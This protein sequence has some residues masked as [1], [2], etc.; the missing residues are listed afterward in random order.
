MESNI[1]ALSDFQKFKTEERSSRFRFTKRRKSPPP[2]PSATTANEEVYPKNKRKYTAR[3]SVEYVIINVGIIRESE[4]EGTIHIVRGSKLPISVPRTANANIVRQLAKE[5]HSNH[6]QFFC[7]LED[8]TLLY[9]DQKK[10]TFIPGTTIPFNV[11][12][13]KNELGKPFSK[14]DL[15]LCQTH[16][17]E[18]GELNRLKSELA[19]PLFV[20]SDDDYGCEEFDADKF[21]N[22]AFD[23]I[24]DDDPTL[25]LTDKD[26]PAIVAVVTSHN[27]KA[28]N[29]NLTAI[30]GLD[31]QPGPSSSGNNGRNCGGFCPVCN[32][33]IP[34]SIIERHVDDC[35]NKREQPI[36]Y[37]LVES[38]EENEMDHYS[39]EDKCDTKIAEKKII[40]FQKDIPLLLKDCNVIKEEVTISIRRQNA[41]EDFKRFF[42][43]K[44]NQKNFNKTYKISLIGE[45][46]IDIGGVSREFYS[47]LFPPI[48][49][50]I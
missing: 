1:L 39:D 22:S 19:K 49:I 14:I 45:P 28:T 40:N 38:D 32:K 33:R 46:A 48:Y 26:E 10:V 7:G 5:K 21:L 34:F 31:Q 36:I 24:P 13:Y 27:L 15:Y 42:E 35:L 43:K 47:G 12:R 4:K 37:N 18:R 11:E 2:P 6:D 41:F 30:S 17:L 3:K 16:Q 50:Y 25:S 8:W 9:P 29:P 23:N 44:W 20:N